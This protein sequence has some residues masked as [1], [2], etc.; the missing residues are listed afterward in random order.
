MPLITG[1]L[2]EVEQRCGR[3]QTVLSN[4]WPGALFGHVEQARMQLDEFVDVH[5]GYQWRRSMMLRG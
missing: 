2:E 4:P 5:R 3:Q 1:D